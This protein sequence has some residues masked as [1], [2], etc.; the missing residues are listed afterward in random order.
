VRTK[1]R[2][3]T[4][5]L[6]DVYSGWTEERALRNN[7]HRWVKENVAAVRAGLPFPLLGI[8]SDNGG[9]FIN[10]QLLAFCDEHHISATLLPRLPAPVSTA[11]TIT[12]C[13]MNAESNR[14]TATW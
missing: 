4:L 1:V 7:A 8:D 14:K 9:E 12:V 2:C 13:G 11:K 3:R 6:T 5:T 10:H